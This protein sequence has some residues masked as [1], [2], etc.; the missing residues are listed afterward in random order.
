MAEGYFSDWLAKV[1][2]SSEGELLPPRR[3]A[4]RRGI[5]APSGDEAGIH[6]LLLVKT[7][8]FARSHNIKL[9]RSLAED[10]EPRLIEA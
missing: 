4:E 10:S 7:R 1:E 5:P 6:L 3:R 9:L 2:S 8:Y